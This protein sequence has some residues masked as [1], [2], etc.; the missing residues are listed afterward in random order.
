MPSH[1]RIM[2]WDLHCCHC[3]PYHDGTMPDLLGFSPFRR[4]RYHNVICRVFRLR[5]IRLALKPTWF[6]AH[7]WC[8]DV[9]VEWSWRSLNN[10]KTSLDQLRVKIRH[11][12]SSNSKRSS[13]NHAQD[14]RM[15]NFSKG[16]T[17]NTRNGSR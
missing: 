4:A 7:M 10:S 6:G 11:S 9:Y 12:V 5:G 17:L 8:L 2:L 16:S 13:Q 3:R 15:S 1:G 14:Q